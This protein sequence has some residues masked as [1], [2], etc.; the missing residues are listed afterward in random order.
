MCAGIP[1]Q[2]NNILRSGDKAKASQPAAFGWPGLIPHHDRKRDVVN[3]LKSPE[4]PFGLESLC[5]R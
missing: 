1:R 2:R 4:C 3:W 5:A